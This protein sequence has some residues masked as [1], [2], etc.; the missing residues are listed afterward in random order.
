MKTVMTECLKCNYCTDEVAVKSALDSAVC[1]WPNKMWFIYRCGACDNMNH[2]AIKNGEVQEGTLD[3]APGP[4][5]ITKRTVRIDDFK[6]SATEDGIQVN[7]QNFSW[8]LP[9]RSPH[10]DRTSPAKANKA[11]HLTG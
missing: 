10:H 2:V 1:C 9:R 6:A 4:C 11:E 3:G 8:D 7:A 5:F